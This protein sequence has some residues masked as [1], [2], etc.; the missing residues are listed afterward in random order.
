MADKVV[1]L[2]PARTLI[3]ITDIMDT[4]A[5]PLVSRS[6]IRLVISQKPFGTDSLKTCLECSINY[7]FF[8]QS[9]LEINSFILSIPLFCSSFLLSNDSLYSLKA[10]CFYLHVNNPLNISSKIHKFTHSL[11]FKRFKCTSSKVCYSCFNSK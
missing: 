7:Y 4:I 8:L 9:R 2:K 1:K 5:V 6:P 11:S 10:M 3:P